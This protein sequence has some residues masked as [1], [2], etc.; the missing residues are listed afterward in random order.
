MPHVR[1][2][3]AD[4]GDAGIRLD[5]VVLRH[6]ADV[7][8]ATRTRVQA[9]IEDGCIRVNGVPVRRAASRAAAGDVIAVDLP[10]PAPRA[11]MAPEDLTLEILYE[12][13]L[14]LAVDKR[15]GIVVH[16]SYKHATGTLMNALLS[17]AR[18]W[19]AHERPSIVGRL[20]KQTTGVVVVA[21]GAAAHAALQRALSSN[22]S[23][24]DYL[25]VV[26][27][28]VK[29][30]RGAIELPLAINERERRR[31]I[32]SDG[33]APSV[34][35]FERLSRVSAPRV[36]LSLLRC[37]LVTGRRHQIRVHLAA[38][39]WPIVG[40]PLYGAPRWSEI[41]DPV[42]ASA[43][44]AFPR[45]ALHAWRVAF[46]HPVTRER[47]TIDAPVPRDLANLLSACRLS[48]P[49]LA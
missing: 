28:R 7:G 45:Q 14:L 48:V 32:V 41:E 22:D 31:I 46:T 40:D 30:R 25:A 39:E 16:P 29:L 18:A 17:R 35:R 43:V 24:K 23:E 20:D 42:L 47:T 9:W 5:R 3:T 33:G 38:R 26:Y 2:L 15:A 8:A 6:L 34:T 1:V 11:P 21:K 12:D 27:G 37:R 19:P 44:R 36:G 10:D 4:R 49:A 13:D